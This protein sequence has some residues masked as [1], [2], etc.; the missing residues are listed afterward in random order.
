MENARFLLYEKTA[1]IIRQRIEEDIYPVRS[2]IPSEVA[3]SKELKVHR[4]SIKKAI[5]LLEKEE[6]LKCRATVGSFVIKK[7]NE[8]LLIG[9]ICPDLN[10][11]FHSDI[12]KELDK[13]ANK[14]NGSLLV[15]ERGDSSQEIEAILR[16][17]ESGAKAIVISDGHVKNI[18]KKMKLGLPLIC[19][20][21]VPKTSEIDRISVNIE[22]GIFM[23][24]EHLVSIGVKS[25]GYLTTDSGYLSNSDIKYNSFFKFLST[26][27]KIHSK[28]QWQ[29]YVEGHGEEGGRLLMQKLLKTENLPEAVIC[30][31]D[32]T[33]IGVIKE[34]EKHNIKIPE[35]LKVTGFDNIFLSNYFRI[36]LTTIDYQIPLMVKNIISVLKKRFENPDKKSESIFLDAKLIIRDSTCKN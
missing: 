11:P 24:I 19:C 28:S 29:L 33:A 12:L 36:P 20:G 21:G 1:D 22:Q 13:Q 17:K 5:D 30:F 27:E 9:Y 25:F 35:D 14:I 6:I 32:W 10:D 2:K 18:D 23:L 26:N 4:Y 16:Q 8:K 31:N 3:L 15:T 34:A 7:P